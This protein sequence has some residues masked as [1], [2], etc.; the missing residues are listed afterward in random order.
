MTDWINAHFIRSAS[1]DLDQHRPTGLTGL[2]NI[3]MLDLQLTDL[4]IRT[5]RRHANPIRHLPQ[6]SVAEHVIARGVDDAMN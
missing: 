5:E 3:W 4:T 6:D 2:E 1:D